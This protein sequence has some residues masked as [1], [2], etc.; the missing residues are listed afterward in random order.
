M[1]N[2][3]KKLRAS[4]VFNAMAIG[5]IVVASLLY[6]YFENTK[7]KIFSINTQANIEYVQS[8]AD[9]LSEDIIRVS[10]GNLF[11]LLQEDEII[12]EYIESD[13]KLFVT[14]KY[15]YI[16]LISQDKNTKGS[17]SLLADSSKGTQ[18]KNK[19]SQMYTQ[20][21]KNKL[22]EIYT[23]KKHLYINHENKAASYLKPIVINKNVEAILVVEFS[24]QEQ[25]TISQELQALNN[26]FKIAVG[27][28]ILIFIFILWFS[29]IDKKRERQKNKAF[30]ALQQSKKNLEKETAKVHELNNSLEYRVHEEINKNRLKEAQL[31]Q[32][33][34]LAQMGEMISMIAHQWRQPLAAI[35]STSGAISLKA[36]LNTLD[37]ETVTELA[38][39]I[40]QYSQ[41][42]SS[43]IDDFREFFKPNKEKVEFIYTK[44]VEDVFKIIEVSIT[45]KNILLIKKLDSKELLT[46]YPNELKQVILNLI[47]NAED[48]LLEKKIQ[49]PQITIETF[50]RTLQVKDNAG[51]VPQDIIEKIFDPYFSTKLNANGTG[52]GLYMSKTIIEEHCGGKLSVTN[53]EDGAVFTI[54]L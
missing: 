19:L 53:S 21:D 46:S 44:L 25:N 38:E 52:L 30:K 43:T 32:Q 35:S 9:N 18:Q 28:F 1:N 39:K 45:N 29:Y 7:N 34:R 26:M 42:L 54:E 23:T 36:A 20:L 2:P 14:T 33:A 50:G 31:I 51:G 47:K 27:F 11:E 17:F 12:K 16:Y 10:E 24:L 5:L 48:I 6:M 8:L 15:K 41:H 3:S 13:L 40:S 22:S 4:T 37:K 49:N